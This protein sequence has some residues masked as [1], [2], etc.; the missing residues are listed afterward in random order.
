MVDSCARCGGSVFYVQMPAQ[1]LVTVSRCRPT[2]V[3]YQVVGDAHLFSHVTCAG[4]GLVLE[5]DGALHDRDHDNV[6]VEVEDTAFAAA[7]DM[8]HRWLSKLLPVA[9]YPK[10]PRDSS[11]SNPPHGG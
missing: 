1:A 8:A 5:I 4:C 10:E 11:A 7:K 6:R 2:K 9:I 3:T